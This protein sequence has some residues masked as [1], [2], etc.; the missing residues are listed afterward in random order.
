MSKEERDQ[1]SSWLD[2]L[3]AEMS[4]A[5][6]PYGAGKVEDATGLECWVDCFRDGTSPK[7]ALQ[8]DLSHGE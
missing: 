5:G 8:E 7:D 2:R 1:F 6:D 4:K 3:E